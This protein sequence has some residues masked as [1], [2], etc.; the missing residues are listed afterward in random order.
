M[1]HLVNPISFRLN[2]VKYW[3]NIWSTSN[4]FNYSYLNSQDYYIYTYI[5]FFFTK[6]KYLIGEILLE[7]IKSIRTNM[8]LNIYIYIKNQRFCSFLFEKCEWFYFLDFNNSNYVVKKKLLNFNRSSF[9]SKII[10]L[11]KNYRRIFFSKFIKTISIYKSLKN[12]FYNIYIY[13]F[14][15]FKNILFYFFKNQYNCLYYNY[16]INLI[17][18]NYRLKTYVTKKFIKNHKFIKLPLIKSSKKVIKPFKLVLSKLF[19]I[20]ISF[21]IYKYIY[22]FFK[23]IFKK[24]LKKVIKTQYFNFYFLLY[25]TSYFSASFLGRYIKH[26]LLLQYPL[27]NVLY[28][29]IAFLIKAKKK[30]VIIG[31]KIL[32]SGRF[33]RKD[34]KSHK[35]KT[36]GWLG[37]SSMIGSL[38]YNLTLVSLL[39]SLCG[40]KIWLNKKHNQ[41]IITII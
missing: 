14:K 37:Y 1:A 21:L 5:N 11:K 13:T 29:I 34:R 15:N 10:L 6:Y 39:N 18:N 24:I 36:G 41:N 16:N 3:N 19:L 20:I 33:S 32:F 26:K 35:W 38:D 2:Y 9:K 25:W 40:I 27:G 12:F 17:L 23:K 22:F 30:K 31:F 28:K 8:N 7:N 4:N